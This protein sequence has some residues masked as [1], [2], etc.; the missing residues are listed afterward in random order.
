MAGINN[1]LR[2]VYDKTETNMFCQSIFRMISNFPYYKKNF[3]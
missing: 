1:G 2:P 3:I